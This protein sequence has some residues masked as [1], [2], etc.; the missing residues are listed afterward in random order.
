VSQGPAGEAAHR[1][2]TLSR[3]VRDSHAVETPSPE[4]LRDRSTGRRR[5]A[6]MSPRTNLDPSL[7]V[8]GG[9][10]RSPG[11][12][13]ATNHPDHRAVRL[14]PRHRPNNTRGREQGHLLE[15]S[16]HGRTGDLTRD[17]R[18]NCLQGDRTRLRPPLHLGPA[19]RYAGTSQRRQGRGGTRR[20]GGRGGGRRTRSGRRREAGGKGGEGAGA[21]AEEEGGGGGEPRSHQP[22]DCLSYGDIRYTECDI[23]YTEG[24]NEYAC[25]HTT[26]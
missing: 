17:V 21:G 5:P 8:R 7:S 23:R 4:I 24:P 19:S 11:R 22:E 18:W 14:P 9:P 3:L 6:K 10:R 1:A 12:E 13:R 20:H 16:S 2:P 15:R 26:I 25:Y